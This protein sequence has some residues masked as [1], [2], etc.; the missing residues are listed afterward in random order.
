M[1]SKRMQGFSRICGC[2][3]SHN[4][5]FSCRHLTI[6]DGGGWTTVRDMASEQNNLY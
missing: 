5:W 1:N 2:V 4:L 3:C 6:L